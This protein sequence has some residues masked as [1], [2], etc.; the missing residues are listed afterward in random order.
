MY[1][2]AN[3]HGTLVS[4]SRCSSEREIFREENSIFHSISKE[5]EERK[6]APMSINGVKFITRIACCLTIFDRSPRDRDTDTAIAPA[7]D[8]DLPPPAERIALRLYPGPRIVRG[9][10]QLGIA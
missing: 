6:L 7:T 10:G 8:P 4:A 2:D 9:V 3:K 1:G 5:N